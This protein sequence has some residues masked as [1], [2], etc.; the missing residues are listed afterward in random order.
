MLLAL[1]LEPPGAAPPCDRPD[2]QGSRAPELPSS[3]APEVAIRMRVRVTQPWKTKAHGSVTHRSGA[4]ESLSTPSRVPHPAT[5]TSTESMKAMKGERRSLRYDYRFGGTYCLPATE[6]P[7]CI[8]SWLMHSDP[9]LIGLVHDIFPR[10]LSE[11]LG[12]AVNSELTYPDL[13]VAIKL[14]ARR[15]RPGPSKF[16]RQI[17]DCKDLKG[18]VGCARDRGNTEVRLKRR[19]SFPAAAKDP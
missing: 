8:L 13:K 16:V 18:V 10:D 17:D 12:A 15:A 9:L 11:P 7:V 2:N 1:E 3:R 19:I 14:L 5:S 4:D 6:D